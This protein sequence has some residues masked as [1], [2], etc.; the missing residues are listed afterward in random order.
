MGSVRLRDYYAEQ[1]VEYDKRLTGF[2]GEDAVFYGYTY[3]NG[4]Q[5]RVGEITGPQERPLPYIGPNTS[6]IPLPYDGRIGRVCG[7]ESHEKMIEQQMKARQH[8]CTMPVPPP[9][10]SEYRRRQ[11]ETCIARGEEPCLP[12]PCDGTAV[13]MPVDYGPLPK[14]SPNHPEHGDPQW[15]NRHKD[16]SVYRLLEMEKKHRITPDNAPHGEKTPNKMRNSRDILPTD[17][18]TARVNNGPTA[19]SHCAIA[20]RPRERGDWAYGGKF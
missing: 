9:Q 15:T 1:S 13:H 2:R 11:P 20:N 3:H 19:D 17:N 4:K 14:M 12:T 7:D 10:W 8:V 6:T 5:K 18:E 16:Y